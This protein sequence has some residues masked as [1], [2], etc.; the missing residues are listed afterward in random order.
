MAII[1][2]RTWKFKKGQIVHLDHLLE[3]SAFVCVEGRSKPYRN[4]AISERNWDEDMTDE[5]KILK[6]FVVE[7]C[8]RGGK[9]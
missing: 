3:I 8:V 5:H 9:K 7:I 1:D 2:K 6:D 4:K